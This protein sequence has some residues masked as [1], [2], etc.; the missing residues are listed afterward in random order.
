MTRPALWILT[1]LAA[2]AADSS[3]G[4]GEKIFAAS[5][6][7]GYCHGS[8]GAAARGPR[9]R[10]RKF[11]AGYL[12][13]VVREGIPSTA[14][15]GWKDRLSDGEVRAVVAYVLSL[16]G[17]SG[18]GLPAAPPSSSQAEPGGGAGRPGRTAFLEHCGSC[19]T[20]R[21]A[22]AAIAG[23]V[24]GRRS[25][26]ESARRVRTVKLKDGETFPALI[27]AEEPGVV[28]AYD[29]T[30]PPPVKRSLD[31]SE[32][33]SISEGAPWK[34]PKPDAAALDAVLAFLQ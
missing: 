1:P 7:V 20:A 31:R 5:C 12:Y 21:G 22:G 24:A 15:P 27:A 34:H 23:D 33:A 18:A 10:D 26:P 2:L 29:L 4:R 3:A 17:E 11:E 14:M 8:A 16:S 32:I 9:L 6:A 28:R 19:H 25:L 13:K 30:E